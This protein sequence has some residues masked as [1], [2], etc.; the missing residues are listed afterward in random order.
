MGLIAVAT[1]P[2]N[3]DYDVKATQDHDMAEDSNAPGAKQ[4]NQLHRRGQTYSY[5]RLTA[6]LGRQRGPPRRSRPTIARMGGGRPRRV[7]P[8][9]A[10]CFLGI[11]PG[12]NGRPRGCGIRR[13]AALW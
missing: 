11:L 3:C 9:S 13:Q 5:G 10:G 1:P 2:C 7:D 8:I 12:K 6:D 4:Y